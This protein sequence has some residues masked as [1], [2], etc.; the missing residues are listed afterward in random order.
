MP[1]R[2]VTIAVLAGADHRATRAFLDVLGETLA[3][4]DDVV[5]VEPGRSPADP[6]SWRV[7]GPRRLDRPPSRPPTHDVVVVVDERTVPAA[8]WANG[9]VA[10]L[11]DPDVAAAAARTNIADGDELLVGVPYRPYEP[12]VHRSFARRLAAERVGVV[13]PA[14]RLAGPSLAVRRSVVDGAGGIARTLA[15]PD[16]IAALAEHAARHGRL[17]VAESSYLHHGGGTAPIGASGG[18]GWTGP[19]SGRA[20]PSPIAAGSGAPFVS[21]CLIVRDEHDNLPR[22][23]ASLGEVADEVVV[24]DTGS[25]D[26]T[27]EIARAAGAMVVDGYWDDDFAR[28]RNEALDRCRG[29]WVL[30]LDADEALACPDASALRARLAATSSDVE[31]Y[32]V[33]VDNLRGTAASTTLT[34]PACRLFR[35]A[36]GHWIGRLHEQVGA[37]AGTVDLA[38]SIL[39]DGARITHW[40]YLQSAVAGRAKGSR[41]VRG[42][43]ADLAGDSDL[44]QATRLLNLGRSHL[45]AHH[46]EEGIDLCRLAAATD[47]AKPPTIR[48]ALRAVVEGLLALD[49][50]DEAL[51]EVDRLRRA[52]AVPTL[53]DALEGHAHVALEQFDRALAAFDR[54]TGGL[55]D[56]GFEYDPHFVAAG[57]AQAL[58]GLGRHGDAADTL[59]GSL[60]AQGGMDAHVGLLIDSLDRA[61]RP[62]SE[63]V[64]AVPAD[65]LAAF[66]PQLLQI[67]VDAAD[68]A[69]DAW[70]DAGGDRRTVLATAASVTAG[71]PIERQLVWS[72]RLRSDGLPGSC[73]L[74]GTTTDRSRSVRER[75]LAAAVAVGSF[76]DRRG[77]Q[78]FGANAVALPPALRAQVRAEVA[79]IAPSL[80]AVFDVLA[81]AAR[82]HEEGGPTQTSGAARTAARGPGRGQPAEAACRGRRV[83]VVDRQVSNIRALAVAG[84]LHRAGHRVTVVHPQP[85]AQTEELLGPDGVAVYG[86]TDDEA[87]ADGPADGG[88]GQGWRRRCEARLARLC[89]D[90][91]FDA[92]VLAA[93]A[94]TAAPDVRRLLPAAHLVVDVDSGEPDDAA[95]HADLV[96]RATTGPTNGNG[97]VSTAAASA[98]SLFPAEPAVPIEARSG[99]C[100][101]GDFRRATP[102]D[103]ERWE[104]VTAPAL[105]GAL[106]PTSIAVVG[107]DPG[108]R[109]AGAL[110]LAMPAGPL[111]DPT[112]WLRTARAV[113]VAVVAGAEH[114]L[115]AA[116]VSGTPALLVPDDPDD[117]DRLARAVAALVELDKIWSRMAP[118]VGT[119][120]T[121]RP[122]SPARDEAARDDAARGEA[123]DPLAGL[124]ASWRRPRPE[125]RSPGA[126]SPDGR[127]VVHWVGDVFA[128]H[129]LAHANREVVRRLAGDRSAFDVVA[130]T[131]ERPPYPADTVDELDGVTVRPPTGAAG[132]TGSAG[133]AGSTAGPVGRAGTAAAVEVR[134]Q[135]PPNFSPPAS[136]RLVL[137]QPWEFGELPAEWVGPIRD[138]VDELWVGTKWGRDCAVAS[139]V[140]AGKVHVVPYGVDVDRFR[141][142]GRS[143]ALQTT[144]RTRLLFVGG[145]I[146]RKGIDILLEAYL[147]AFGPAD[148]V[149]L[150]VKPFGSDTVYRT[151]TLEAGV[152]RAAA[153]RGAAVEVVDRDLTGDEMAALFRS[154][155]ALVHPYRGEGFGLPIAEA[156]ASGLPVVVPDDGPCLDFCDDT[157]G[158][159]VPSRRVRIAPAEW[160]PTAGG[161]WWS[162]TSRLGLVAALRHV[163]DDPDERRRRGAAGR[164]R[165]VA[166]FTWERTAAVVAGRL[167][168]VCGTV[169]G[170]ARDERIER[171]EVLV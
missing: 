20:G 29:Q 106:G 157:T 87:T 108:H 99:V 69:L 170:A 91:P 141:P 27:V 49:R 144:K 102:A 63:M 39:D 66:C 150:V 134:H 113:V 36:C 35:R 76:G 166:G 40:G 119:G 151:S 52:T 125:E 73:P 15:G 89:A 104:R 14:T 128:H 21:A 23:L 2:P 44:D 59:L 5:L 124:P 159:L 62:L 30:W 60:R 55:D 84:L 139:G 114:W 25:V 93:A 112:P 32:L 97:R 7:R 3:P 103:R 43:F 8:G 126:T 1:R 146:E 130:V 152:R 19:M 109:M 26:D 48:L 98:P 115:S 164:E 56:D 18:S 45:L 58:A 162:E 122:T 165:I 148:D 161:S 50:P 94:H 13:S 137:M 38:L 110:P 46:H 88:V 41:N 9:L 37:R 145:C 28:A 64:A 57:R 154:C 120:R 70:Y 131:G 17:V 142:D 135:W 31:G 72:A 168:A 53:A 129:S 67:K 78:T 169:P 121:D 95:G 61:G 4:R 83:L 133:P 92:V 80:V 85:A 138:V 11:G 75:L 34:H 33:H 153:G 81:P 24:Y 82:A 127:S 68:R 6:R 156:M 158:W 65:R 136:G 16:P 107:D 118:P 147:A 117:A 86:W 140:P 22:C 163:V 149:C 51:V 101:V 10:A 74:I 143:L 160:T 132:S 111:A 77:R 155:D 123:A 167:A 171:Q 42:A 96:L 90:Q 105:A 54:V 116:A 100:V 47:G 79:A 71:L 12:D